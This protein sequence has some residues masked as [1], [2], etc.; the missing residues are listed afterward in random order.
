VDE[1]EDLAKTLKRFSFTLPPALVDKV[2][3]V[4]LK[5][6]M[7]RSQVVREALTH[8]MHHSIDSQLIYGDGNA[9]INYT[10][11]HHESR[12]IQDLM[13]IQHQFDSEITSSTHIHISGEN[14]LEIV[15]CEVNLEEI[16]KLANVIRSIK[17]INS[18]AISFSQND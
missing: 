17:G 1:A 12:V 7:N 8:W 16:Q 13:H 14:C 9:V 6:D 5:L 15:I 10:Y 2:D 18:F 4:A 3:D 11:N